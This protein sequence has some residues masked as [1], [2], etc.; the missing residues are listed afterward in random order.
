MYERNLNERLLHPGLCRQIAE[1]AAF[2]LPGLCERG[3]QSDSC[4]CHVYRR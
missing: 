3:I 4:H 2:D 1:T